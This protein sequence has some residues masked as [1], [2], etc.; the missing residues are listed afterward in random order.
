MIIKTFSATATKFQALQ[1][2]AVIVQTGTLF[3]IESAISA[4]IENPLFDSK[5][6]RVNFKKLLNVVSSGSPE[7]KV[8]A[9]GNS[10]LGE[11]I[12]AFSTLPGVTCP[13]AGDC[14]S[15]C[16]SFSAWRYPAAYMRQA[17]SAV[18]MRFYRPAIARA[19]FAIPDN[20]T[21]R[22]YVDGD[23]SSVSDVEF[24]QSL[25]STNKTIKAYGYSKSFSL[26]LA[27][28]ASGKP[29]ADNYLLNISGGHNADSV[30]IARVQ[31]LPIVRGT[32]EAVSLGRKVTSSEHGKPE[33]NKALRNA[34]G[35]NAFTC[36]GQ[37]NSCTPKGHACGLSSFKG[38]NIIIAVH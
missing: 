5:G 35:K 9:A 18:L 21:L 34:Y 25:L 16:Y 36:P 24:W 7:F 20:A 28:N 32:F 6:W 10:K 4:I 1:E 17:Q 11:H 19:F 26:L 33:T 13:G 8:F 14:I 31:S 29:W 22:L 27:Y 3:D 38:V 23:F 37:C 12:A 15:F 2:L 30:T